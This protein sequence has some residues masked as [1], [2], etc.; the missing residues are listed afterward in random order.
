MNINNEENNLYA[1]V[2]N[3]ESNESRIEISNNDGTNSLNNREIL[4]YIANSP[5][6]QRYL[7][8]NSG[9]DIAPNSIIQTVFSSCSFLCYILFKIIWYF[10]FKNFSNEPLYI[11]KDEECVSLLANCKYLASYYLYTFMFTLLTLILN[12]KIAHNKCFKRLKGL[13][14][15]TSY[16]IFIVLFIKTHISFFKEENCAILRTLT[17]TWIL[18]SYGEILLCCCCCCFLMSIA[19]I[20]G[21]SRNFQNEGSNI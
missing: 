10:L 11:D 18:V 13:F 21:F 3:Y 9:Q 7:N 14:Y 12:F 1:D 6:I 8:N 15:L 4:N 17:G 16:I 5:T 19:F 20:I 2:R